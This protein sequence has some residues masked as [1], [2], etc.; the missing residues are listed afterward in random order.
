MTSQMPW[1]EGA[2]TLRAYFSL[3]GCLQLAM[4]VQHLVLQLTCQVLRFQAGQTFEHTFL[5]PVA[6][7]SPDL[8]SIWYCYFLGGA[9]LGYF[10]H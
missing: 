7:N 3:A 10:G 9:F 6:Y 2:Q 1:F 8:Y 4:P 5:W